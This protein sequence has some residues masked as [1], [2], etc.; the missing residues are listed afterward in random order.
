MSC[1]STRRPLDALSQRQSEVDF[2]IADARH[3]VVPVEVKAGGTGKLR[4]LQVMARENSLP[5]A[6]RFCSD[7]PSIFREKRATAKGDVD[8]TLLSLPHY[9]V[10]QSDRLLSET[11]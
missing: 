9:L 1:F 7:P 3:R 6:V 8:F 4:S 2:V 5:L 10:Q 11:E